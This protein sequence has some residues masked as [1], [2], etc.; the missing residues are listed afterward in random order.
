MK[1]RK[2]IARG[3]AHNVYSEDFQIVEQTGSYVFAGVFDGCSSGRN[4]HIASG[5]L[6]YSMRA[7]F[8]ET[9]PQAFENMKDALLEI[10]RKA[11]DIAYMT[12][13][14]LNTTTEAQLSTA[15]VAL[16]NRDKPSAV[17]CA[18]GDGIIVTDGK[19]NIIEQDNQPD[20]PAY[21]FDKLLSSDEG[22]K[23]WIKKHTQ[24]FEIDEYKDITISTDGLNSFGSPEE[25]DSNVD[26][27]QY[28][29][30][31]EY[32]IENEAML[33]RKV[34]ILHQKHNLVPYDDLSIVRIIF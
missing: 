13:D 31:D 8:L 12:F 34:N 11:M 6:G 4:S 1:I 14:I 16:Y 20:Y 24:V 18:M 15:I 27:I 30:I 9:S 25:D 17:I 3:R 23:R 29:A 32:L 33:S 10:V 5:I 2:H 26:T 21:Y 7:A 19:I 22:F 28:L